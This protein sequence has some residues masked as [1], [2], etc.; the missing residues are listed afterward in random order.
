MHVLKLLNKNDQH[1]CL[2]SM[3]LPGSAVIDDVTSSEAC[4]DL[5]YT[6]PFLD[7]APMSK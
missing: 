6:P 7:S 1:A 4:T 3:A 5:L 2:C